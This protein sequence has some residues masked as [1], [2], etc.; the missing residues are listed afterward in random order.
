MEE[1]KVLGI[2]LARGGSKTIPKKNI[3]IVN[4]LPLIAYTIMAAIN[5]QVIDKLIVSTDDPEIAEISSAYGAEII[6]RP[7][8]LCR[9]ETWSRDA[10]KWTVLEAERI[11]Q[12]KWP[13]VAELIA[14]NPLKL[15]SDIEEAVYLMKDLM[16][17]N[18]DSVV[19]V[20]RIVDHH[21]ARMKKI[22]NEG[23]D[24]L[25]LVP[26]SETISEK[27]DSRKQDLI[28]AYI[29][30]GAI[31]LMKRETILEK[32]DRFGD[33]I[34]PF[35]MPMSRGI[36]IDTYEDLKYCEFLLRE[37]GHP[38]APMPKIIERYEKRPVPLEGDIRILVT[39]PM[40]FMPELKED[41]E[42]LGGVYYMY[43]VTVDDILK[44]KNR[45]QYMICNPGASYGIDSLFLKHFSRL[46]AIISPSTGLNH[47]DTNY[48]EKKGIKVYGLKSSPDF[49]L[50]YRSNAFLETN[51]WITAS[52]EYTFSLILTL[53]RKIPSACGLGR[54]GVWRDYEELLR[55]V[56][57][58]GKNLGVVGM[59]RIGHNLL[60]YASAFN[61]NVYGY[62]PH[63]E[64]PYLLRNV[65][66]K[67]RLRSLLINSHFIC[68]CASLT[69][70]TYHMVDYS[71]FEQMRRKPYF[72]NTSRGELVETNSLIRALENELI[73]GAAIDVLENETELQGNPLIEYA[74]RHPDKLIITPHIAG[75]TI[76]S[77]RKAMKWAIGKLREEITYGRKN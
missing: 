19:S 49:L 9:D 65:K 47:I 54:R 67:D 39:A 24:S 35:E 70:E 42:K 10:L 32:G 26:F 76:D 72:I 46:E 4:G 1:Y 59:G 7:E 22:I 15:P 23:Y 61:M 8:A 17:S 51:R 38:G 31:Y 58:F 29:R 55:G 50:D 3:A 44:L 40:Y 11:Y 37:S 33:Y 53:A 36:N 62:D 73:R 45:F 30:N 2:V 41:L 5:S 77:Q 71:W 63:I 69:P 75:L 20:S 56:E 34:V 21:P 6:W 28:P 25:R 57:L 74:N 66:S 16:D 18:V 64:L 27:Q 14:T 43:N 52:S 12:K 48:A 13:I 60:H 68:I